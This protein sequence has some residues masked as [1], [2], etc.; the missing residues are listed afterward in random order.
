[1]K[2]VNRP[3]NTIMGTLGAPEAF[4][5]SLGTKPY[6][7]QRICFGI[8]EVWQMKAMIKVNKTVEVL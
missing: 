7:R 2:Q 5:I 1:M 4:D 6:R 8:F 3:P